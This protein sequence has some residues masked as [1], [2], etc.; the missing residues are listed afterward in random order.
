MDYVTFGRTGLNVSA[1]GLGTGGASKLGIG[2]GADEQ[3]AIEVIHRSLELGITYYDTAKGYGTEAVVGRGLRG[4]REHI[5]LSTK[6][7][8]SRGDGTL[9]SAVEFRDEIEDSL[10]SLQTEVIDI[11]HLHRLALR[12]YDY[13]VGEILPVLARCK[14][15]GKIRFFG[16]S[17]STSQ[18]ADHEMLARVA[19]EGSFDVLMA[20]FNLFNQG[21]RTSVFHDCLRN[22]LA[23]EI[24]G[25][26]R[27][28]YSRP[29]LL[30]E[31]VG[32]LVASGELDGDD[33]DL[34]DPLGFLTGPGHVT[35]LAE[36][37][38]RLARYE[39][40]VHVVLVGTGNIDHLEENIA[41][42][43]RGPLPDADLARIHDRFGHLRVTRG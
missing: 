21:A 16:V 17:E 27:G 26:A 30:R 42:M 39:P 6:A 19:R 2:N 9:L 22:N 1:I 38:Y 10:R 25:A 31:M 8:A 14:E 12:E 35:T 7:Y 13:A 5:V 34:E 20:G 15:Q 11:Y 37:S 33:I 23:V 29:Q 4:S 32:A 24:M 28:P 43:A 40:G 36:A 18:D 41:S 3:R